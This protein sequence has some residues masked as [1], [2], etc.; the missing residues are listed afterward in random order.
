[1]NNN[2]LFVVEMSILVGLSHR[3]HASMVCGEKALVTKIVNVDL[4][5]LCIFI[6]N[7]VNSEY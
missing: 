1:M 3:P 2:F 5:I 7:D 4:C 6:R